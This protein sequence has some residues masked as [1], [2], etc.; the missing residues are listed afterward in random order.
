M[1]LLKALFREHGERVVRYADSLL[2]AASGAQD[3]SALNRLHKILQE[4][5][6]RIT[7]PSRI[8]DL[9]RQSPGT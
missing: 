8:Y 7:G 6:Q 9:W 4:L 3:S 1:R 5:E 2:A